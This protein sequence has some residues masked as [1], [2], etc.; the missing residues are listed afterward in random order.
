[1]RVVWLPPF[2]TIVTLFACGRHKPAA[3]VPK[4]ESKPVVVPAPEKHYTL[5]APMDA[6]QAAAAFDKAAAGLDA[7]ALAG[8]E[9]DLGDFLLKLGLEAK[10]ACAAGGRLVI[11]RP[12]QVTYE[13]TEP[14][15]RGLIA[16]FADTETGSCA[17][18]LGFCSLTITREKTGKHHLR[19]ADI[20]LKVGKAT[21]SVS[22]E[23]PLGPKAW[24]MVLLDEE[25]EAC[26][27]QANPDKDGEEAGCGDDSCEEMTGSQPDATQEV[28]L[29]LNGEFV[30]I[31]TEPLFS[32]ENLRRYTIETRVDLALYAVEKDVLPGGAW[33]LS[34]LRKTERAMTSYYEESEDHAE[35]SPSLQDEILHEWT[36]QK[37]TP[38]G[39]PEPLSPDEVKKLAASPQYSHLRCGQSKSDN[40]EDET[41]NDEGDGRVD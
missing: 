19:A 31:A 22:G 17:R 13:E 37:I 5:S 16:G 20:Q 7:L 9:V 35:D 23:Y 28:L 27:A 40:E 33:I 34:S 32:Y 1:M 30:S 15:A 3:T 41:G 11:L 10:G 4:P 25:T 18:N 24:A 39:K 6:R 2:L 21:L 36:C 14:S 12:A 29:F 26:K 8:T 38:D